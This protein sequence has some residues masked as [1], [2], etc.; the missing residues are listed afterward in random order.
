MMRIEALDTPE[1]LAA[2]GH[3]RL[4]RLLADGFSY[5]DGESFDALKTG[6]FRNY[7]MATCGDLPYDLEPVFDGLVASG[8]Y[9]DF[10]AEYLRIFEVG[11]GVP[12][13]PLYSGLFRGGRK[14]VMEELAR[15]YSYFGLSIE[16]GSG[17]LPDHITTEL[18][19]MHFLAFKELAA[20]DQQ[21][22]PEPY[23]RAQAD[24]LERQLTNWLPDL[25]KRLQGL[26]PPPFYAALAW[27]TNT[28]ARAHLA[29]LDGSLDRNVSI[30]LEQVR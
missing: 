8:T 12:P 17:E 3:S 15:F 28:A 22:D 26:E 20:L 29:A 16:H 18:E 6:E 30:S 21:K 27:L 11:L 2:A 5:P 14:A 1:G 24:F 9:T 4:Y 25:E 23:R 10:Q 19:F 7:A 13:C